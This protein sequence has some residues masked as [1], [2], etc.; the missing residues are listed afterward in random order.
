MIHTDGIQ[1]AN[2]EVTVHPSRLDVLDQEKTDDDDMLHFE[3]PKRPNRTLCGLFAVGESEVVDGPEDIDCVV[4]I[5][6]WENS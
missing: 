2:A 1:T 3:D 5:D 6:L 4:C